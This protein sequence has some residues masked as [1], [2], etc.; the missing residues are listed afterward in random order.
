MKYTLVFIFN[1]LLD[2]VLLIYKLKGFS[3]N[4]WNGVGGKIEEGETALDGA[5]REV[6]E[7][8]GADVTNKIKFL[9]KE[10]FWT[11][12]E[13]NVFTAIC[14][15]NDVSQKETEPI[16]WFAVSDVLNNKIPL[17][18]NAQHFVWQILKALD[19]KYRRE[20]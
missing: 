15:K 5:I 17:V 19:R 12:K 16:K 18:N 14:N 1:K 4:K 9:C 8:T 10:I 13:L 3:I 11:G 2:E 7:E 6:K 20:K